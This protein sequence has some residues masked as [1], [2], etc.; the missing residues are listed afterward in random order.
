MRIQARPKLIA[1]LDVGSGRNSSIFSVLEKYRSQH[2]VSLIKSSV[3]RVKQLSILF[4]LA[5]RSATL[6]TDAKA[7]SRTTCKQA[8]RSKTKRCFM[9]SF[10]AGYAVLIH[11]FADPLDE[12]CHVAGRESSRSR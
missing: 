7:G 5:V 12:L 10:L 8:H 3:P 6:A 4:Q 9:S 1:A 11:I 2:Y